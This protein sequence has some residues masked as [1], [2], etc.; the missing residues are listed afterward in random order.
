MN[1]DNIKLK[2][3]LSVF[4][5]VIIETTTI[6]NLCKCKCIHKYIKME[7]D[8]KDPVLCNY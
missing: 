7:N 3:T 8:I 4:T 2:N 5:F 6:K 1:I